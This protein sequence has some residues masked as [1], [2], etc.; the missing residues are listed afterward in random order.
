MRVT[1]MITVCVIIMGASNCRHGEHYDLAGLWIG[2][3]T[4]QD[5]PKAPCIQKN[6]CYFTTTKN[7]MAMHTTKDLPTLMKNSEVDL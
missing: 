7:A 6:F 4:G 1:S 3:T 5:R 2:A